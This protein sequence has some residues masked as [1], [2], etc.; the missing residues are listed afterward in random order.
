MKTLLYEI[1][2]NATRSFDVRQNEY[3]QLVV[4]ATEPGETHI[5]VNLL[6]KNAE[7]DILGIVLGKQADEI[8][9]R[10]AQNHKAPDTRSNLLVKSALS[11]RSI[12]KYEGFINVFPKAQKTDA[13]QRNEN[14][15]L[16][17]EAKAESKPA[18]EIL[19]NDVRCTH[20][21]TMGK[22][23]KEQLFYLESRG[24]SR[25]QAQALITEGF[26]L[27]VIEKVHEK[28]VRDRLIKQVSHYLLST[29]HD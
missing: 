15:M 17:P 16:S 5:S 25:K 22:V 14:L 11:Q 29:Q 6:G 27:S 13:Y 3:L 2:K 21:A 1:K 8:S 19:A 26:L 24:V 18:L 23:D 20:S 4:L 12:F 9:I 7:A 10:T 28:A